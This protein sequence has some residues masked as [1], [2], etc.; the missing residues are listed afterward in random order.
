MS[1]VA[2]KI[3]KAEAADILIIIFFIAVFCVV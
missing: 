1:R 2:E 3:G